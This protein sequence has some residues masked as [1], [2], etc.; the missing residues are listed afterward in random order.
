M[1]VLQVQRKDKTKTLHSEPQSASQDTPSYKKHLS[2]KRLLYSTTYV[3]WRDV[4]DFN[5][6]DISGCG[7]IREGGWLK[8]H[9][10][11]F[12]APIWQKE[13]WAR[14]QSSQ[15]FTNKKINGS[16]PKKQDP[17]CKWPRWVSHGLSQK[18]E[19]LSHPVSWAGLGIWQ[20]SHQ[21]YIIFI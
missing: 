10:S 14:S 17:G 18:S 12:A 3:S 6:Q 13:N 11:H 9:R 2:V 16:Q 19:K 1:Q 5:E 7:N 21:D 20:R 4:C 15:K 8:N